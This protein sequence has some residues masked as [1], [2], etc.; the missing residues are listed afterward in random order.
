MPIQSVI[1]SIRPEIRVRQ[2][3]LVRLEGTPF[4]WGCCPQAAGSGDQVRERTTPTSDPF[5]HHLSGNKADL[6]AV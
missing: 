6:L 2:G 3:S 4:D 5:R 1:E